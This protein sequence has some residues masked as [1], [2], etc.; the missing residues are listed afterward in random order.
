MGRKIDVHVLELVDQLLCLLIPGAIHHGS[1]KRRG[2]SIEWQ[3]ALLLMLR[4]L[5]HHRLDLSHR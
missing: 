2:I 3:L 5:L 1:T 4:R